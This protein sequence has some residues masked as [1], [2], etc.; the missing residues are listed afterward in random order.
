MVFITNQH[1][2]RCL[3]D[4]PDCIVEIEPKLKLKYLAC[5]LVEPYLA[6]GDVEKLTAHM[7]SCWTI[8]THKVRLS[9]D[10]IL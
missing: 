1:C 4:D 8:T 7:A 3:E 9:I 6:G 2:K 10:S 5:N